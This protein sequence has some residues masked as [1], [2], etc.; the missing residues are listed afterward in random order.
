[1]IRPPMSTSAQQRW[2]CL[3]CGALASDMRL[4]QQP[5]GLMCVECFV[6]IGEMFAEAGD[7]IPTFVQL[8]TCS[9]CS[10]SA[11]RRFLVAGVGAAICRACY[12]GIQKAK[13]PS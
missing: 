13:R 5:T 2:R 7:D 10:S 12:A 9:L 11:R 1:M 3:F 6:Q 8:E 4:I